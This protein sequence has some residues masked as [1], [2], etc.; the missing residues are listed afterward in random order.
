M[1]SLNSQS[2][3]RLGLRRT[4]GERTREQLSC[5]LLEK[6]AASSHPSHDGEGVIS[7]AIEAA[8]AADLGSLGTAARCS[9]CL[10]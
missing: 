9:R 10:R 4:K 6:E 1:A 7:A 8:A 3:V 2:T 5:L